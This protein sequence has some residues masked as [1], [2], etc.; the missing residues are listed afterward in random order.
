MAGPAMTLR[1]SVLHPWLLAARV[2]TL[3]AA[4][5]P[6]LVGAALARRFGPVAPTVVCSCGAFAVLVQ[7]ATNLA[8]DLY[9]SERGADTAARRGPL[10]V[11]AAGLV[12]AH[13]MRRALVVVNLAAVLAGLPALL[14]R[15][16]GLAPVGAAA[17]L[18]GW[19]YTGG[20]F[21]LAYHG[22]G[23]LFVILFFG[24][25]AV[26]GS[27]FAVSGTLDARAV[28]VGL[29]VGLLCDNLLVVNN[30]RDLE[31]DAAA[32]KRT[33]VVRLGRRFARVQ[34][35]AQAVSAFALAFAAGPRPGAA[36]LVAAPLALLA[37]VRFARARSGPE[38][39]RALGLAAAALLAYGLALAA[40]LWWTA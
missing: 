20:P 37:G 26:A 1:A 2:K 18:A 24:V 7:I 13:A 8:N 35:P 32:S 33:L 40:G 23:D 34:F 15:G 3:P 25:L 27:Q 12:S 19:A 36:T 5:V 31:T 6:V 16:P 28:L 39:N 10:R 11:T 4:L 29:G 14:A 30:T 22:L 9:D 21:P 38:Y 17:M